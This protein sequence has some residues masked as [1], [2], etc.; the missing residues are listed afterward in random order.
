[1]SRTPFRYDHVAFDL[2]GTVI[3]S[4]ADLAAATNHV[5]RTFGR[6]EIAP[7]SVHALVGEGARRLVERAMPDAGATIVDEGVHRFLAYYDEHL[8]DATTL[9]PGVDEALTRLAAAGMAL[10][11]LSN[12][13]EG[14][15]R[16]VLDGLGV[17][18]RFRAIVGGDSLPTRKP[19]PA[20]LAELCRLTGSAA[21]RTLLVGDSTV[22]V[23]TATNG[24]ADF[25][26]AGWGFDPA[27]LRAVEPARVVEAPAQILGVVG[28]DQ[29]TR[30]GRVTIAS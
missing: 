5:L 25:C 6:P 7:E 20:G 3:D 10:T 13:P 30:G 29:S 2:D 12:K 15:S 14:L 17:S 28:L 19:D 18:A 26:G 4:R 23:A 24:G 8:L 21:S 16:R 9:Y 22:D 27:R 1:V 11:V